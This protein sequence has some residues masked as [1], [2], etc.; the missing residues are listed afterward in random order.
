MCTGGSWPIF[1]FCFAGMLDFAKEKEIT[2][3]A[4]LPS[5]S[6]GSKVIPCDPRTASGQSE[7]SG[8]RARERQEN[9]RRA[10]IRKRTI[11][12]TCF[13]ARR[14]PRLDGAYLRAW[15]VPRWT[16]GAPKILIEKSK[17]PPRQPQ[18]SRRVPREPQE[19]PN[20]QMVLWIL[21]GSLG[22]SNEDLS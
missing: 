15:M 2:S 5:H 16:H 18:A 9:A 19:V 4:I 8:Q 17:E 3:M 13:I 22:G 6:D 10:Q 11:V 20:S 12:R 21:Q 14:T 1:V 7:A